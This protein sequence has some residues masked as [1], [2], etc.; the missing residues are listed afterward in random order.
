MPNTMRGTSI[1]DQ[2][3]RQM[4]EVMLACHGAD[5][6][7]HARRRVHRCLRRGEPEWAALWREVV[8]RIARQ[9]EAREV[10]SG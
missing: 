6:E 10:A 2:R 4:V 8:D 7:N 3:I 1:D 5:A 9:N